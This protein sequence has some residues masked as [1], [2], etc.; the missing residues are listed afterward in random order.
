[1]HTFVISFLCKVIPANKLIIRIG[2]NTLFLFAINIWV[3][4]L[5][6]PLDRYLYIIPTD[7]IGIIITILAIFISLQLNKIIKKFVPWVI[8][9]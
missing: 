2:R 5:L 3:I 8:G 4:K 1:M 6:V 7:L 9:E